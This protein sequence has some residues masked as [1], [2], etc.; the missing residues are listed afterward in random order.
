MFFA[1]LLAGSGIGA[2]DTDGASLFFTVNIP[3]GKRD[4]EYQNYN[5]NECSQIHYDSL[6]SINVT[7]NKHYKNIVAFITNHYALAPCLIA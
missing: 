3:D 2:A 4:D 6:L 7:K 5:R 1:V